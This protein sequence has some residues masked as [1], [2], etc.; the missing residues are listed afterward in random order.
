[1]NELQVGSMIVIIIA[2][3]QALKYAGVATRWIPIIA[4]VLG[5]AGALFLGG[6]SWISALAGIITALISSGLF[7]GFKKTVLNK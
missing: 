2:V 1:M 6:V 7:S 3:C 4:I 5:V